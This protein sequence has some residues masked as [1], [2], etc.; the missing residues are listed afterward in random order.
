MGTFLIVLTYIAYVFIVAVYTIKV[1][2]WLKL[3][4]HLRWDLYPVIHE[5]QY[6]YGGSYYEKQ[7]WWM[8]ARPKNTGR[9]LWYALK[10]NFYMGE[11]FKRNRLYWFFLL[12]WHLGF[13]F[14]ILFHITCF[15]AATAMVGGITIAVDSP[16]LAG[17]IF[18]GILMAFAV[19][20][21]IGGTFGCIGMPIV[22]LVDRGL[23]SYAMP[24][25]YFNYIFFLLVYA[26]GLY[27]WIALDPTLAE[28]RAY[29]VGLIT[30]TPPVLNAA[31]I[32]HIILFDIFLIYLPFTRSTHY[33]TRLLAYFKIRWDDEPNFR[34]STL[35]KQLN[36]LL[37]QRL[38]WDAP[39][40]T[41]G[42]S[43]V[44]VALSSGLPQTQPETK[45]DKT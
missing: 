4:V 30:L 6:R 3:P 44:E 31:T 9:S 34:G 41:K 8:Q 25:N 19:I 1:R 32:F 16:Q 45:K 40:I 11:Y 22:R 12:P 5:E 27:S 42:K 36:D 7:E 43:W 23:R 18:Y 29:W 35:E 38:S 39:H 2:K 20:A 15:F 13:I 10:D 33:I 17:Q 14:I 28:Y 21:F 24:M 37:A 26:S